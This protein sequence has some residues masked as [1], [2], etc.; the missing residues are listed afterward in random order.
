MVKN[1][2]RK[3]MK[4]FDKNNYSTYIEGEKEREKEVLLW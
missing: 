4:C 1:Y 3:L 2:F